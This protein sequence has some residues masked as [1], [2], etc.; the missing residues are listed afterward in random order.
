MTAA[1]GLTHFNVRFGHRQTLEGP[2]TPKVDI[3]DNRRNVGSGPQAVVPSQSILMR[4][5][6]TFSLPPFIRL[7]AIF[8]GPQWGFVGLRIAHAASI[9]QLMH[10]SL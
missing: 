8:S 3:D 10:F 4:R 7:A 6:Q 5:V 2:L 1:V 9:S